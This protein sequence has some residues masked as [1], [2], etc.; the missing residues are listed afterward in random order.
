M[1]P[2]LNDL[3]RPFW[4]GG[5]RGELLIQRCAACRRWIHPP[6]AGSCNACGGELRPEAASGDATVFTFT[7]NHQQFHPDVAPP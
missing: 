5:G 3:N 4:T 6:T 2:R 7:V 1:L